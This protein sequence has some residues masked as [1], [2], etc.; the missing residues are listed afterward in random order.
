M[1]PTETERNVIPVM[2]TPK[3]VAV[4]EDEAAIRDNYLA[5]LRRQGYSVAGYAAARKR[6]RRSRIAF[7]TRDHRHQSRRRGRR[8][9]RALPPA[10]RELGAA[11]H[12][13][14]H[15]PRERA[16]RRLG[17]AARRGRL[18]DQASEPRAPVGPGRGAVSASR[19]AERERGD[20]ERL[21]QG[22]LVLDRDRMT[23]QWR[24]RPCR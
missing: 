11:A 17:T 12:H 8:W 1:M 14:S 3:L 18:S 13:F 16:R 21:E 2:S 10:A 22:S 20:S 7:P 23:A 24:G 4:V 19:G 5:G 6:S 9:L 15:G